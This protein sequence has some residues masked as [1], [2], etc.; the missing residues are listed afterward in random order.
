MVGKPGVGKTFL[1]DQLASE[2]WCLFDADRAVAD[3]PDAIREMNPKR[4]VIDDA[5]LAESRIPQIR[6]LRMEMDAD[7][8]IVAVTWP[9]QVPAV[10]TL[11]EDAVHVDV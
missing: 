8:S 11:L 7:F 6:R 3:L 1:L 2:G 9:G 4:I 5:H 10:S